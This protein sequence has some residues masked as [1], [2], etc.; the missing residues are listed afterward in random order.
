MSSIAWLMHAGW[1]FR[2]NQKLSPIFGNW[3]A[4]ADRNGHFFQLAAQE[5]TARKK[6]GGD[7]KD[8][9]GQLFTTQKAKPQ[10]TDQDIAFM[11]TSNVFGGSDTTATSLCAAFLM[12]LKSPDSYH[13]LIDEFK[14][15]KA[16]GKLSDPIT[17]EEAEACEYLQAVMYE[18]MRLHPPFGMIMDRDVPAGGMHIGKDFIPEGVSRPRISIIGHI[19]DLYR[20]SLE[21]YHGSSILCL[22]Y[23][24]QMLRNSV[25][26]DGW[27]RSA[28]A[29]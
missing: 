18:S 12:L 7:S 3:L 8:I 15:K 20:R 16:Q 19:S 10:L 28:R 25:Q 22:R 24:A 11:M 6:R 13:R 5:I 9:L 14:E 26:R 4:A 23:G 29:I 17:F 21:L 1:I 2:L 27:T